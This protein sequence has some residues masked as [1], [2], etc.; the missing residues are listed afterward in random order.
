M[1]KILVTMNLDAAQKNLLERQAEGFACEFVYKKNAD[2]TADDLRDVDW[3]IGSPPPKLLPAATRLEWLQIVFAG[4]DTYLNVPPEI[5]LTN[6]KGAYDVAV[7]E[8]MLALTPALTRR[9]D[10]YVRQQTNHLWQRT[11]AIRSVSGSTVLILGAGSIGAAYARLVK[12]LGA[13]VI[14]V[15]RTLK[16]KPPHFDEM[17]TVDDPD[18]AIGRAICRDDFAGRQSNESL[19]GRRQACQAQTRR[20]SD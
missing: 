5:T 12:N 9:L 4:A 8:H 17:Y 7:S 6:A 10:I 3:I 15:R 16:D 2:L 11:R 18:A 19:H 13:Y 1:K 14:G 20:V